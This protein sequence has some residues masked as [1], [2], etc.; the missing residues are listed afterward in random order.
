MLDVMNFGTLSRLTEAFDE[1]TFCDGWFKILV[2]GYSEQ[3]SLAADNLPTIFSPF[4]R[5][6]VLNLTNIMLPWKARAPHF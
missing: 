6:L 5:F 4:S 2:Q 1:Y 3:V